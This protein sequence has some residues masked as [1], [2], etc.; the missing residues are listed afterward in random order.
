MLFPRR[1]RCSRFGRAARWRTADNEEISLCSRVSFVMLLGSGHGIAVR[2]LAD[3]VSEVSAGNR[4]ATAAI[5][6]M[7]LAM[8]GQSESSPD[9]IPHPMS[10]EFL[11]GGAR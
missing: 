7:M 3:A 4:D 8:S 11:P 9:N 5:Y 2:R 6:V 10:E 1:E